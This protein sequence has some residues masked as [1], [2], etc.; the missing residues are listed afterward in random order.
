MIHNFRF[1][2]TVLRLLL[3]CMERILRVMQKARLLLP[4]GLQVVL[5]IPA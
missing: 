1:Y 5:N 3:L 4:R 2:R